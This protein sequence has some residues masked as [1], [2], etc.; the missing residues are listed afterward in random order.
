MPPA[1][2]LPQG[3][4]DVLV[5]WVKG[6]SGPL[7]AVLLSRGPRPQPRPGA[8]AP[9]SA[10]VL[11]LPPGRP[12]PR[13]SCQDMGWI[14]NPIDAFV[15]TRLEADGAWP[16]VA[17]RPVCPD[18]SGDVRPDRPAPTPKKS[19]VFA[20]DPGPMPMN[21]WSIGSWRRPN[22]ARPGA[23]TGS[24]W[25]GMPRPTATTRLGQA[26]RLAYR[27]YVIDAFNPDNPYDRF[28]HEQ[29]AGDRWPRTRSRR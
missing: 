4:I 21:G 20:A 23:A 1:G 24:T 16:V 8:T 6:S 26:L 27:D 11:A 5:N 14:R 7:T 9:H 10:G 28:V 13:P 22:T 29:L 25:F 19:M 12:S 17:G 15:L 3:E 2:K 18:P